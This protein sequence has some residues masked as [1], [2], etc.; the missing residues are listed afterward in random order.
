MER[1]YW[2]VPGALAGCSRPGGTDRRL[3]APSN[4]DIEQDL[5]WL[6][7]QGIA[8]LLSLTEQP[9]PE[10]LLAE[11]GIDGLH[12]PIVDMQPPSADQFSEALWFIDYHCA[13]GEPVA[14]HC[15]M[16]QG[17]TGSILAAY[18]IRDGLSQ[19]Q[20]LSELR[21]I[22]PHAVENSHQEHALD[23][24]AARRDWII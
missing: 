13:R 11:R 18:L 2:V 1:F 10:V 16:G 12:I 7:G 6:R 8:A 24:F 9:V 20:A 15:L 4:K 23:A 19:A 3:R 14:V 21:A 22:C 5:D 17:R